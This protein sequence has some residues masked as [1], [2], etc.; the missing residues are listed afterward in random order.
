MQTSLYVQSKDAPVNLLNLGQVIPFLATILQHVCKGDRHLATNY[1]PISLASIIR[2]VM[3]TVVKDA[4]MEHMS[5]YGE[6]L[7]QTITAFFLCDCNI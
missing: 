2:K 4:L 6:Q 3:E 5:Q 7:F 1:R